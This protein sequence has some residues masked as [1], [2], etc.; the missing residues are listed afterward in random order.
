[1]TQEF[2]IAITEHRS[3]GTILTPLLIEKERSYNKVKKVVK[4]H[5]LK[6]GELVLNETEL[7]LLKLIESAL[8][9][10]VLIDHAIRVGLGDQLTM[11]GQ[12]FK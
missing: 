3:V 11:V 7:Q 1:M 8:V 10:A 4:P 6:S 2:I 12:C 5:D 9:L